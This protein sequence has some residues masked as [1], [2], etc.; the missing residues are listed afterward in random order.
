MAITNKSEFRLNQAVY[1]VAFSLSGEVTEIANILFEELKKLNVSVFFYK[2]QNE[3]SNVIAKNLTPFLE[4]IYSSLCKKCIV[5]ISEKTKGG[6]PLL[7]LVEIIKRSKREDGFFLPIFCDNTNIDGIEKDLFFI[8]WGDVKPEIIAKS[9]YNWVRDIEN[10][11]ENLNSVVVNSDSS[12]WI[13]K[14][15]EYVR[16]N[17]MGEFSLRLF[18]R[19][20]GVAAY[21]LA[22][23]YSVVANGPDKRRKSF[24]LDRSIKYLELWLSDSSHFFP[25]NLESAAEYINNDDNLIA[26]KKKYEERL[27]KLYENNGIITRIS[28]RKTGY[29]GCVSADVEVLT[30]DG[31]VAAGALKIDQKIISI[32]QSGFYASTAIR[33]ISN[34]IADEYI[35]I[36][37]KLKCTKKHRI[38]VKERGWTDVDKV[39]FGD[40]IFCIGGRFQ[41]VESIILRKSSEKFIGIETDHPSH[42]FFTAGYLSHNIKM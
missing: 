27:N 9:V 2:N 41:A 12:Q 35:L 4:G 38:L 36:N 18:G 28:K 20:L 40:K 25:F 21:N 23:A 1:D 33:K 8:K 6:F 3:I 30:N 24:N 13:E 34:L 17:D 11:R 26:V 32:N 19:D 14:L 16:V 31:F 7:E 22:C 39:K 37:D 15:E 42:N 5:F 29:S 10:L